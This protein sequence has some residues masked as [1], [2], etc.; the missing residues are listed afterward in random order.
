MALREI[1]HRL[2]PEAAFSNLEFVVA[3]QDVNIVAKIKKC[4][5]AH[6]CND[7]KVID[8]RCHRFEYF[9]C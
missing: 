3:N 4:G 8:G 7:I 6:D 5:N 2:R 9:F 1:L